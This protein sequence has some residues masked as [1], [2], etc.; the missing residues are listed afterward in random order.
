MAHI[1][2]TEDRTCLSVPTESDE[3]YRWTYFIDE[4]RRD[5]NDP[6]WWQR[7]AFHLSRWNPQTLN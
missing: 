7:V 2:D 3:I 4:I 1:N 5:G 6:K